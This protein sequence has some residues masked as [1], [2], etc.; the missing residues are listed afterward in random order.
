M[1]E[2]FEEYLEPLIRGFFGAKERVVTVSAQFIYGS[3]KSK[4]EAHRDFLSRN[5]ISLLTPLYEY[6][7]EQAA[8]HYWRFDENE[9]LY[10]T[11]NIERGRLRRTYPYRRGVLV[12]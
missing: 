4:T 6:T 1:G 2:P 12:K 3:S 5:V 9:Q 10:R 8:L 7:P 11:E